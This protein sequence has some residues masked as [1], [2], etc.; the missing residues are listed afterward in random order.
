[1]DEPIFLC[2]L[3]YKL[4]SNKKRRVLNMT[5]FKVFQHKIMIKEHHLDTFGH[6]NNA[7]Y[8]ALL[9]AARWE[10]LSAEGFGLEVIREQQQGPVVLECQIKF[11]K[12]LML[13]QPIII[14][15]EVL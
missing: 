9:E 6:V 12:E 15:S 10:L 2:Y 8:L 1:M 13:R 4:G 11:L 5:S 14:E 3:K 7:T